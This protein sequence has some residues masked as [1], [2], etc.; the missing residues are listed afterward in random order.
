[1]AIGMAASIRVGYN[2]GA[3]NL[4]AARRSGKVALASSFGFA[5][6]AAGILLVG[7]EFI[8]G[9]YSSDPAVTTLAVQLLILVAIYQPFDDVQGTAIGALRGFKDTRTPFFVAV[10][11]Y[12]LVGFP[13]SWALGF[14]YFE[15]IDYGVFGY[16]M[17]LIAGLV[18]AAVFLV[19]R[20][21]YITNRPEVI[22]RLAQR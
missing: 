16:W 5:L 9:L 14:G 7:G 3:D 19:G 21:V 4:P 15:S 17:G 8:A 1:M 12:W 10:C 13:A 11:A 6:F 2:V 18:V 20:F 22:A